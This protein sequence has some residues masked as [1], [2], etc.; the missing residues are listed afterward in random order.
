MGRKGDGRV[1]K[2]SGRAVRKLVGRGRDQ[3]G[4][5][6]RW[7]GGDGIRMGSSRDGRA[8]IKVGH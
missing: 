1:R 5:L 2:G 3:G 4:L 6:E 8:G 7:S